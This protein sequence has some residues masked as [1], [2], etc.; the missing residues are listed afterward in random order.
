MRGTRIPEPRPEIPAAC[1]STGV[2][3]QSPHPELNGCRDPEPGLTPGSVRWLLLVQ[4]SQGLNQDPW[5]ELESLRQHGGL[6]A[7]PPTRD[8][9]ILWIRTRFDPW[10]GQLAAA[11]AAGD[12]DLGG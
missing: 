9:R 6:G 3:G 7:E 2:W 11:G 12:R 10:F 8:R 1:G 4:R 5:D